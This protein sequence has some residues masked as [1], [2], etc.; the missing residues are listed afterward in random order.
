MVTAASCL[1]LQ[2]GRDAVPNVR[3]PS[4]VQVHL[5][6][7]GGAHGSGPMVDIVAVAG[8]VAAES[9]KSPLELNQ[10]FFENPSAHT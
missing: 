9:F 8:R 6:K 2:L 10:E 5:R 4:G 7:R 3:C 1:A